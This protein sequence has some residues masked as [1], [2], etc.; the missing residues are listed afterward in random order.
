MSIKNSSTIKNKEF[1]G[2]SK[3]S[4]KILK[5]IKKKIFDNKKSN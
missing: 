3:E 1:Y 2:W 4:E 5:D